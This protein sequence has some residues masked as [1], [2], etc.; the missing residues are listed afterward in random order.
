MASSKP[1]AYDPEE[2]DEATPNAG[3]K[4]V[5]R[6]SRS[7]GKA[8]KLGKARSA[9]VKRK[10]KAPNGIHQRRNKRMAW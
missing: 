9:Q 5:P 8:P 1:G 4:S 10:P 3:G 7:A 6:R 2:Y